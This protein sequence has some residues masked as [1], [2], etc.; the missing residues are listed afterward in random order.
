[1]V[2]YVKCKEY[3]KVGFTTD[4]KERLNSAKTF[5][6][7]DIVLLKVTEGSME[8]ERRIHKV[9]EA[10]RHKGEWFHAHSNVLTH[11]DL[12][13]GIEP[14]DTPRRVKSKT[15]EQLTMKDSDK[16]VLSIMKTHLWHDGYVHIPT[17]LRTK[18]VGA[19]CM[20]SATFSK[21][22]SRLIQIGY[23]TG[24]QGSYKI[25]YEGNAYTST[26]DNSYDNQYNG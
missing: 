20:T 8:D 15:P 3:I 10:Y 17:G 21:C 12:Q 26:Y 1:M 7:F 23:I 14:C 4:I 22:L 19:L 11:I 5:N 2:Y 13:E 6:P 25:T 18:L 16:K 9:L 24:A